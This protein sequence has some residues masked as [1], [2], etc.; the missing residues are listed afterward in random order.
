[1]KTEL[2]RIKAE[3][4]EIPELDHPFTFDELNEAIG[5]TKAGKAAGLD[6][7][8]P[9]FIKHLGKRARIW[10]LKF[11]NKIF[12]SANLPPLLMRANI[13]AILKHGKDPELP[14]SYR[15]IALLSV[16]YKLLEKLII[17]RTKHLIDDSLPPEFA[18]F[19]E[20]RSCTEQILALTSF[21]EAG[22][23]M[24]LKTSVVLVDLSTAYDTVWR[25]G[26]M[27][28]FLKA[29]P[30]KKIGNL[31]NSMLSN[32]YYRVFVGE[33][34]S[35][36]RK[37]SD[38]FAQGGVGSPNYFNLYINDLPETMSRKFPFADDLALAMQTVDLIDAE[39]ILTNDMKTMDKYYTEWHLCL[40]AEKTESCAF[41][42]NNQ[43]ANAQLDIRVRDETIPYNKNPKYLGTYLDRP[44]TYLPNSEKLSQKLKTRNN[45]LRKIAGTDWGANAHILRTTALALVYSTA[46][47]AAPVWYKCAHVDKIDCQLNETMRIITGSVQSTPLQWLPVLSNIAPPVLRREKAAQK[48]WFQYMNHPNGDR[49]PIVH[50]LMNPPPHRLISRSPIWKDSTIR[51]VE[52]SM[53]ERWRQEWSNSPIVENKSIIHDPTEKVPGFLLPRK[54][55]KT[56]NRLRTGHG[57]C[58]EKMFLWKYADSALCDCDHSSIQSMRHIIDDCPLRRFSGG[59]SEIHSATTDSIEWIRNLDLNL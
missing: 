1:M 26:F 34:S 4:Q 59:I 54:I 58:G 49:I 56:M 5:A 17:G 29:V 12:K 57:C 6:G 3:L 11:C 50:D 39:T 35:R 36:Y 51:N 24:Q 33:S 2:R 19:R 16:V 28:K 32:R 14:E 48:I 7:M 22:F 45:L 46:E 20:N 43:L 13:V 52:Y 41:H 23:E 10:L 18:G 25:L 15:P 9:E 40:N 47:Y 27:V 21:I 55:W 38:G 30:S 8:Y 44:L 42:L 31:V 53:E 37:L